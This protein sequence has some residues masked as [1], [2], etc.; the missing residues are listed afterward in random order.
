MPTD[1]PDPCLHNVAYPLH[2]GVD[3]YLQINNVPS[4][5]GSVVAIT[6]SIVT[7]SPI[8]GCISY[9]APPFMILRVN[10]AR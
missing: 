5:N 9:C 3:P 1:S 10:W 7:E 8:V 6:T 4:D 2:Q